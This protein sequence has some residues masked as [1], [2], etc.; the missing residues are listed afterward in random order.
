ML[1]MLGTFTWW[2]TRMIIAHNVLQAYG[3]ELQPV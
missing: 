1:E 3:S 2:S